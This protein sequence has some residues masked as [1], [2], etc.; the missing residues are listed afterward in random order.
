MVSPDTDE[1]LGLVPPQKTGAT[2]NRRFLRRLQLVDKL[3]QCDQEALL[4]TIDAL[5]GLRKAG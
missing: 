2:L 1:I 4:R 3:P 5:L